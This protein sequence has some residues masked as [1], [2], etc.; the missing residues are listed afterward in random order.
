MPLESELLAPPKVKT[1]NFPRTHIPQLYQM[2]IYLWVKFLHQNGLHEN[3][4]S[5]DL[6]DKRIK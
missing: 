2:F 1:S 4:I 6:I 5:I 3:T